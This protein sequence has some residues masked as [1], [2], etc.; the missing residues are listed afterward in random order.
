MLDRRILWSDSLLSF[1]GL[2]QTV[3]AWYMIA[4]TQQRAGGDLGIT[5]GGQP[6]TGVIRDRDLQVGAKVG[7]SLAQLGEMANGFDWDI[8]PL[9][10]FNIY[11]PQRGR[12]ANIDLVF[13]AQIAELTRNQDPSNFATAL[14]YTGKAPPT[15]AVEL[16][17]AV[18]PAA[19]RWEAQVGNPDAALQSTVESLAEAALEASAEI[20][21]NYSLVLFSGW[22]DPS[23]LWLGD[24]A[25]LYID[26]GRLNIQ[27]DAFRCVGITIEYDDDGAE[28]TTVALGDVPPSMTSRLG[29]YQ[30]RIQ[31][32]ERQA[33][34]QAGWALDAPVGAM[35]M[36]PGSSPPQMWAL[37]DGTFLEIALYPELFAVIG[38]TFG[39]AYGAYFALPDTRS[40]VPIGTGQGVD[41]LGHPLTSYSTGQQGGAEQVWLD[42]T[43]LPVHWHTT[44]VSGSSDADYPSHMHGSIAYGTSW[45][46]N[47]SSAHSHGLPAMTGGADQPMDN[48]DDPDHAHNMP[49]YMTHAVDGTYQVVG[50]LHPSPDGMSVGPTYTGGRTGTHA[51]SHGH[52]HSL[53]AYIGSNFT[54]HIHSI[55]PESNAHAH[56][57][58]AAAQAS[59]VAGQGAPHTNI[60]PFIAIPWIIRILP[61][62]RPNPN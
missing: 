16:V 58:K 39:G 25:N 19:G 47:E 52:A 41:V 22:W 60:Q 56:P 2:D 42:G 37:A 40:K 44:D 7:E 9:L 49:A 18:F 1:R 28:K 43:Q 12:S 26:S 32:L 38:T 36:W 34:A 29:D 50:N 57:F 53:P 4:D 35:Y 59:S 62:W 30:S 20:V 55:G 10:R 17:E 54:S 33:T 8:D 11:F 31:V 61:P 51:H 48:I 6:A 46:G 5:Y 23:Q 3:I 45:T 21:A 27:G 13:G 14:R 24:V 15:Q